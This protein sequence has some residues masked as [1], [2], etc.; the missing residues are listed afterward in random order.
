MI[1]YDYERVLTGEHSP[2]REPG[3]IVIMCHFNE[4]CDAT[5]CHLVHVFCVS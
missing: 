2:L 5:A 1:A 3:S 4:P